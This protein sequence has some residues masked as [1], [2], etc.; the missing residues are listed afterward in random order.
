MRKLFLACVAVTLAVPPALIVDSA[1]AAAKHRHGYAYREWRGRDGRVYC[2]KPDGTTG[3]VLGGI[4]GALLGRSI[5]SRGDHA[6][7][8]VL[9]ALGGALAGRAIE[10]GGE[11]RCR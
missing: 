10:R 4:G 6:T 1:P 2:R 5:D 9:G 11:P 3:L 7:G 8:T